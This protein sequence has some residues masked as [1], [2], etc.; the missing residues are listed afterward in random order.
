MSRAIIALGAVALTILAGCTT[1][2]KSLDS[3]IESRKPVPAIETSL[4]RI[5]RP[6]GV[7]DGSFNVIS[8]IR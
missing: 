3:V 8:G 6:E 5:H 2:R 4:L 1:M 7:A